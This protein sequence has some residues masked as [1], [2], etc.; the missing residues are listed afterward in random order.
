[1]AT[2]QVDNF[3]NF[4]FTFNIPLSTAGAQ[5]IKAYDVEGFAST[6]FTVVEIAQL[7]VQVDVGTIRFRGELVEFYVQTALKGRAIEAT[8]L[9]AKLYGPEGEIAYYQYPTNITA[10]AI[11]L[12]QNNLH[13]SC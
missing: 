11:G 6:T 2:P 9:S 12:L 8:S 4:T 7:D 5:L 13:H 1:L 10:V 3:G